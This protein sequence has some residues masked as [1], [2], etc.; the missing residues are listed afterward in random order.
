V[1]DQGAFE[2]F[3]VATPGASLGGGDPL[4]RAYRLLRKQRQSSGLRQPAG[5]CASSMLN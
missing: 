3:T 2:K 1:I 5:N 4:V